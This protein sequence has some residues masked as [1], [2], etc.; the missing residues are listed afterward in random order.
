MIDYK[1]EMILIA[2][3]SQKTMVVTTVTTVVDSITPTMTTIGKYF[4][5]I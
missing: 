5:Q 3:F 2:P 1:C 4:I